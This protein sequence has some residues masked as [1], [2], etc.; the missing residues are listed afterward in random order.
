MRIKGRFS[1]LYHDA[2]S[3]RSFNNTKKYKVTKTSEKLKEALAHKRGRK[4]QHD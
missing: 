3:V 1:A 2:L 4:H